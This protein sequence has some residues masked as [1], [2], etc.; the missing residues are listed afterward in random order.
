MIIEEMA[1]THSEFTDTIHGVEACHA[2]LNHTFAEGP[3]VLHCYLG[4]TIGPPVDDVVDASS[5]HELLA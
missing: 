4:T 2:D 1:R 3:D 5:I